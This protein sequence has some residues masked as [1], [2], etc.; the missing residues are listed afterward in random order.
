MYVEILS[1][2][3]VVATGSSVQASGGEASGSISPIDFSSLA[4]GTYDLSGA[5]FDGGANLTTPSMNGTSVIKD[6]VAPVFTATGTVSAGTDSVSLTGITLFETDFSGATLSYSGV[7]GGTETGTV[8]LNG[9]VTELTGAVSGL[10]ANSTYAY[11]LSAS[12]NAGNETTVPAGTFSTAFDWQ[13][14][15]G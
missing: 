13:A 5:V 4:D 3:T 1:G 14:L 9:T 12:D 15:Y 7:A 10:S 11:F 6:T 8:P 2:S